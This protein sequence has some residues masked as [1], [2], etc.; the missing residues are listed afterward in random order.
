MDRLK[1]ELA[2]MSP[3][4]KGVYGVLLLVVVVFA[5]LSLSG[6]LVIGA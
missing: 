3:V 2:E 6:V 1:N 5:A 4:K